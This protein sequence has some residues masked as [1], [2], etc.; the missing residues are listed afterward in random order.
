LG[1]SSLDEFHP[2]VVTKIGVGRNERSPLWQKVIA[3][4]FF[5]GV[6]FEDGKNKVGVGVDELVELVARRAIAA[7]IILTTVRAM[8][9]SR[10]GQRQL[11]GTRTL[12]SSKELR[13]R[14]ASFFYRLQQSFF[15]LLLSD[16]IAKKHVFDFF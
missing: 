8:D 3:N 11:Q 6:G 5:A 14:N 12:H 16:Y 4:P 7:G 10:I 9:V 1:I 2:T 15:G 13:M